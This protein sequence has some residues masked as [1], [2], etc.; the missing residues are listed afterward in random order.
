MRF[1]SKALR[2]AKALMPVVTMFLVI[3]AFH[4]TDLVLFKYYPVIVN[5]LF[6]VVFFSSTFQEKTIIQKFALAAEP[7]AN[8][9]TLDYTRKL[10]YYWSVFMFVNF[11]IAL[12]TVFMSEKVWAVYN[13]FVSYIFVG[14]FFGIEYIV[15]LNFKRKNG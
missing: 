9:A 2:I 7:D 4:F 8:S 5:F 12:A 3:A 15:R 10:T 1:W 6:F 11:L 13:G 14:V